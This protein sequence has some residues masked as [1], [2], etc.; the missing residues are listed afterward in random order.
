MRTEQQFL[1]MRVTQRELSIN[2]LVQ[3]AGVLFIAD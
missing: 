2:I 3:P 1:V